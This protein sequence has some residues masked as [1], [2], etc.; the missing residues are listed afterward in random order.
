MDKY[1]KLYNIAQRRIINKNG[2][3]TNSDLL[4]PLSRKMSSGSNQYLLM[5]RKRSICGQ[6]VTIR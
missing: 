6:I 3:W 1:Q 4:S 5:S 2:V